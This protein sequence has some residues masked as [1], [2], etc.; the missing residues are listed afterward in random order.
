MPQSNRYS[1]TGSE[2][3]AT[4]RRS[5]QEAQDT[6]TTEGPVGRPRRVRTS[7]H[8]PTTARISQV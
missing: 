1:H 3:P 6:F 7:E 5:C 4:L 8:M 2:L